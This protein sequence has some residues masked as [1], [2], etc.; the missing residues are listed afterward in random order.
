MAPGQL[1][2][3]LFQQ[4]KVRGWVQQFTGPVVGAQELAL[5]IVALL[6]QGM[7]GEVRTPVY[8]ALIPWLGVLP[9]AVRIA[10]RRW[11]GVDEVVAVGLIGSKEREGLKTNVEA[12]TEVAESD[13]SSSDSPDESSNEDD[14]DG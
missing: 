3:D 13:E 14:Q 8:A 12:E 9:D 1:D 7:A 6:D 5:K 4:V 10:L 11:S 2:T